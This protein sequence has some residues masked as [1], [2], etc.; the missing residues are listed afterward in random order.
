MMSKP[1]QPNAVLVAMLYPLRDCGEVD[2]S[3]QELTCLVKTL[4]YNVVMMG[5]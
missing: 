5:V 3:L 2:S 1:S 4:G